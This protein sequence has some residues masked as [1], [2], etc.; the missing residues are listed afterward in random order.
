MKVII[1]FV[2][3][4]GIGGILYRYLNHKNSELIENQKSFHQLVQEKKPFFQEMLT[5]IPEI[6]EKCENIQE[7]TK[8][9]AIN[10]VPY[11]NPPHFTQEPSSDDM[12][13]TGLAMFHNLDRSKT[14]QSYD[15]DLLLDSNF[16]NAF[17]W[18][19]GEYRR[20]EEEAAK[21]ATEYTYRIL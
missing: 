1:V 10:P 8:N 2:F 5:H 15:F 13:N 11:F 16:T 19:S 20:S 12:N 14:K 4:L 9:F 6:L 3:L 7:E 18:L 17:L 21:P